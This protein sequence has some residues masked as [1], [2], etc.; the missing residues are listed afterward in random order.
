LLALALITLGIAFVSGTHAQVRAQEWTAW[1]VPTRFFEPPA[2]GVTHTPRLKL[3]S[4]GILHA[5]WPVR[6]PKDAPGAIYYSRWDGET[7]TSPVDILYSPQG[8]GILDIALVEDQPG[9]FRAFWNTGDGFLTS[10]ALAGEA[11]NA[12]AWSAPTSIP[13]DEI[14]YAPPAVAVMGPG[15]LVL[16]YVPNSYKAVRRME[17]VDGGKTWSDPLDLYVEYSAAGG[18]SSPGVVST[19]DETLFVWWH[20]I[21]YPAGTPMGV[22]Y[23]SSSDGGLTWSNPEEV[24]FEKA[25]D[26]FAAANWYYSG[27][28]MR[29]G[30]LLARIAVGGIGVGGRYIALS[31]DGGRTWMPPTN[32]GMGGVEGMQGI[33]GAVDSRGIWYFVEQTQGSFA[34]VTLDGTRWSVPQLIL[35]DKE[36]SAY[37]QDRPGDIENAILAISDGNRLHVFWEGPGDATIWYTSRLVDAP[38]TPP[39]P[40]PVPAPTQAAPIS[41]SDI[42]PTVATPTPIPLVWQTGELE[43]VADPTP[44]RQWI[45]IVVGVMT[46]LFLVS[47]VIVVQLRGNRRWRP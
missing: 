13:T 22:A 44:N 3:D 35:S 10:T 21:R 26:H 47:G 29:L 43:S 6:S 19:A 16:V 39:Q 36:L 18:V 25:F 34:T 45:P 5:F 38:Y 42:G 14:P 33:S 37:C 7:W 9:R 8:V 15:H 23:I 40:W 27:G 20:K 12:Q 46:A 30:A 2:D 11:G 28:F 32:I 31:A 24:A 1:S 17:S 41:R 4:N